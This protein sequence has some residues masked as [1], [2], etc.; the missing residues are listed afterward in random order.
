MAN[1]SIN[2]QR[3]HPCL[4]YR[5]FGVINCVYA[6]FDDL[7]MVISHINQW[8]KSRYFYRSLSRMK[9]TAVVFISLLGVIMQMYL[10]VLNF[11]DI[12]QVHSVDCVSKIMSILSVIFLAIYGAVWIQLS[13]FSY[14][15]CE[16]ICT[17]SNYHD[18][19]RS[20]ICHR[21]HRAM[22]ALTH[23]GW[24]NWTQFRTRC[25]QMHFLERKYLNID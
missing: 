24:E 23:W 21:P 6:N 7:N 25:F 15:D 14:D 5:T 22:G 12:C 11:W 16:N 4:W 17:L 20:L 3:T 2:I 8:G 19:I 10:K 13:H 9:T 18:Q 1:F